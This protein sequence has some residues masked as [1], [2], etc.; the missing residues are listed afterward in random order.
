MQV[1]KGCLA[2]NLQISENDNG[3]EYKADH[4]YWGGQ[5]FLSLSACPFHTSG[6]ITRSKAIGLLH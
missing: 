5:G 3:L 1:C 2:G 6:C 4:G